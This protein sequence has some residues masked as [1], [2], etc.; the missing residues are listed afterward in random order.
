[1]MIPGAFGSVKVTKLMV[2]PFEVL[3]FDMTFGVHVP[4]GYSLLSC[5]YL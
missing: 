2:Q 4:D 3:V 1:M 5:H